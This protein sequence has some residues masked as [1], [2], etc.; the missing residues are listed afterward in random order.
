MP[1]LTGLLACN[2][3]AHYTHGTLKSLFT[4]SYTHLRAHETIWSISFAVFC[5]KIGGGGGGGG[6]GG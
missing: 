2:L 4:V 3:T 1:L 5:L 6:G